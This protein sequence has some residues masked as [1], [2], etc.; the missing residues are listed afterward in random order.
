MLIIG[1]RQSVE[2]ETD[3]RCSTLIE[4]LRKWRKNVECGKSVGLVPT[5]GALHRGHLSLIQKAR[6]QCDF[7]ALTIFVNPTQF[8]P[9]EDLETYP[10]TLESDLELARSEGVDLVWLGNKEDL[11][12]SGFA[13]EVAVPKLANRL[14]GE[15]RPHHFGGVCLIVLKL[16]QLFQPMRAYFGEKDLQQVTIIERMVKDLHIETEIVRCDLIREADGLALSSRNVRLTEEDRT[17]ALSLSKSLFAVQDSWQQGERN[18]ETLRALALSKL[19]PQVVLEY[20]EL[21]DLLDLSSSCS[22]ENTTDIGIDIAV[23]IAAKV[24]EVRLIDNVILELDR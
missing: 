13:T 18:A 14:C 24:G 22:A 10:R 1:Q 6:Q 20:L 17:A 2:S 8:A 9:G 21:V 3:N 16:L 7:V 4:D 15:S 23:C 12:P 5:M 19:A 11:Y